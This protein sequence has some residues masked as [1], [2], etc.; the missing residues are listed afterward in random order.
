M[1][2][3]QGGVVLPTRPKSPCPVCRRVDCNNPTHRRSRVDDWRER[4]RRRPYNHA[5]RKLK[6]ETVAAWVGV[7]GWVCPGYRR[8]PHPSMDLTADHIIPIVAG[9][10]PLGPMQV[11]CRSCNARKGN[12]ERSAEKSKT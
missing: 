4:R 7:H 1:P 12:D 3:R 5:E 6:E 8:D 9:G 10:D 11:L 2:T